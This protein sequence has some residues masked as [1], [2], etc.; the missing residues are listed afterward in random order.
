MKMK[1]LRTLI[2]KQIGNGGSKYWK[3]AGFSGYVDWCAIF[4]Y[5]IIQKNGDYK[6][7]L[8]NAVVQTYKNNNYIQLL[9]YDNTAQKKLELDLMNQEALKE[10]K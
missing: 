3:Y 6:Y 2:K 8:C 7:I 4:V 10:L 5:W 1:N 9:T